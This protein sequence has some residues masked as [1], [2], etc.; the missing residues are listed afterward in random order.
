MILFNVWWEKWWSFIIV[1]HF[2]LY[3]NGTKSLKFQPH[4]WPGRCNIVI[5]Y[6]GLEFI[7][8]ARILK[9]THSVRPPASFSLKSC[10]VFDEFQIGLIFPVY[11]TVR[12]EPTR[13]FKLQ[14]SESSL[15]AWGIW[16]WACIVWCCC[17]YSRNCWYCCCCC[18][19]S[20]PPA[21]WFFGW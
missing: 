5:F 19:A 14:S 17:W 1:I 20:R 7:K 16:W 18:W 21:S 15:G 11:V 9:W 6:F 13:C 2:G 8:C 3:L 4:L 12:P 10:S